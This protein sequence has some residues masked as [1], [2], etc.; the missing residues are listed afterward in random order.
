MTVLRGPR[1]GRP[2][3][4]GHPGRRRGRSSR[5]GLKLTLLTLG[6][7]L[8]AVL[9]AVP[10]LAVRV[11]ESSGYSYAEQVLEPTRRQVENLSEPEDDTPVNVL[12]VGS[13]SRQGLDEEQLDAA[14]TQANGGGQRADTIMVAHLSPARDEI[15]LLSIPRDLR[16]EDEDGDGDR[17]NAAY[18]DGPGALV[19]AVERL[20]GLHINHYVGIDF[21]GFMEVVN[22]LGG[23]RLCNDTGE[24]LVDSHAG[25]D[26]PP[27]CHVLDGSD[28]LAFVRARH[29]DSDFGRMGRQQQFI[30]AVLDQAIGGGGLPDLAQL[31]RMARSI[32]QHVNTDSGLSART[33]LDLVRRLGSVSSDDLVARTYP[34]EGRPPACDGCAAYVYARPEAYLLTRA[35]A[36]DA[37]VLP[38]VGFGDPDRN[39]SLDGIAVELRD[40]GATPTTL[41]RVQADLDLLGLTV[42]DAAFEPEPI[43]SGAVLAYPQSLAR[44]A[45][46]IANFVG[47]DVRLE[48]AAAG[49]PTNTL[50]LTVGTRL[51]PAEGRPA[52]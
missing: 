34:S 51:A 22:D 16:V 14:S 49:A 1:G 27:G 32:A 30:S 20:T 18:G 31:S 19:A 24:R 47:D 43:S 41:E 45:R 23:V 36:A 5:R 29:I 3:G 44:Q 33:A 25:L 11:A 13:D 8:L 15:V 50:V 38:P 39:V 52:R 10:L 2:S 35:I 48:P 6:A 42:E 37:A 12:L 28:A 4:R 26:M 40:G 21:G 17:I 7:V 9:P 46:L